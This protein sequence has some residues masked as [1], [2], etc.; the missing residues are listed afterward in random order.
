[1]W[2]EK[3][4]Q[5]FNASIGAQGNDGPQL[6]AHLGKGFISESGEHCPAGFFLTTL[7]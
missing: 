6:I 1:M 7:K 4:M 5:D 3:T 2:L